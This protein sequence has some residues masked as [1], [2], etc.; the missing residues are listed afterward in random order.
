MTTS[1][2]FA[3]L[4]TLDVVQLVERLPAPNEKVAALDFLVAAGGP[5]TNAAVAF[6]WCG[7]RPT[8]VTALPEHDLTALIRADL[9]RCGVG[10]TVAAHYAGP[11]VTASIMVTRAT[12]DR[13]VVSPSGVATGGTLIQVDDVPLDGVAAVLV[14]GYFPEIALPLAARARSV[15]IPVIIDAGSHKPHTDRVVAHCDIA[16]VSDDFAPPGS[17]GAPDAVFAYLAD[18]GVTTAVITRGPAPALFRSGAGEGMVPVPSAGPVIDTLGA[19]DFFHG[20]LTWR[21]ASLGWD[22]ARLA[23]DIA[24]AAAVAARSLGS[25]GTRT[26]LAQVC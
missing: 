1:A 9:D 21:I 15:G 22:D 16:V 18:L 17:S 3:G 4:T 25:F 6:A 10:L 8:V 5:A 14:D 23:E 26:W 7:G 19:G 24:F 2:I 11:P 12:G 20:A 13:A